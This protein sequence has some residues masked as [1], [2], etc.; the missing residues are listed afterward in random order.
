MLGLTLSGPDTIPGTLGA[1]NPP[2]VFDGH[3]GPFDRVEG[4]ERDRQRDINPKNC[5]VLFCAGLFFGHKP[6]RN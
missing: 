4:S 6:A 5:V 2:S 3:A 1:R